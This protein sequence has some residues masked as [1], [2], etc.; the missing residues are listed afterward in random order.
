MG[1]STESVRTGESYETV[2]SGPAGQTGQVLTCRQPGQL[3]TC[4]SGQTGQV[5]TCPDGAGPVLIQASVR[6]DPVCQFLRSD[7]IDPNEV[8]ISLIDSIENLTIN[9]NAT[10]DANANMTLLGATLGESNDDPEQVPEEFFDANNI[11]I[12]QCDKNTNENPPAVSINISEAPSNETRDLSNDLHEGGEVSLDSGR[13][14]DTIASTSRKSSITTPTSN[15][16]GLFFQKL[17]QREGAS[18]RHPT[19]LYLF[20]KLILNSFQVNKKILE[21]TKKLTSWVL[22]IVPPPA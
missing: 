12:N 2:G 13:G 8:E 11:D 15:L 5:Q 6:E 10:I 19:F 18:G 22:L 1:G 9:V 20:I 7:T 21:T 17:L 3:R 4:P 14:T 16:T